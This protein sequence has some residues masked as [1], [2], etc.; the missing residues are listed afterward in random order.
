MGNQYTGSP[1]RSAY[2]DEEWISVLE[3]VMADQSS[4]IATLEA[5]IRAADELSHA[6]ASV[7]CYPEGA[8]GFDEL[9]AAQAAYA[10]A[11]GKV[12]L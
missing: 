10:E 7:R 2:S 1:L 4:R 5:A 9:E 11:R 12:E 8:V 6:A 3:T